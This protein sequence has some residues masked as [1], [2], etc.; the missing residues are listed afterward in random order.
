MATF[1]ETLGLLNYFSG[2]FAAILVFAIVFALLHQTR[3][4]GES[5]AIQA[6][7]AVVLAIL[8]LIYPDLVNLINFMAPWFVLVFVFLI[9]LLMVWRIFGVSEQ[10]I[11]EFVL[12]DR[13]VNW[14]L[15]TIGLLI[16]LAGIFNVFGQRALDQQ[17]SG[18][19]SGTE[20]GSG[21]DNQFESNLFTTLFNPKIMGVVLV[22]A[23]AIFSIAFLG[24][25]GPSSSGG[26]GGGGH[27]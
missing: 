27:H 1:I 25:S 26:G 2:L 11:S 17:G 4:L 21:D 22:F 8:V 24:G 5:K 15:V 16:L 23:I 19:S 18:T 14:V 13:T 6:L 9:M 7:I 12:G 10:S 20:A 3:I